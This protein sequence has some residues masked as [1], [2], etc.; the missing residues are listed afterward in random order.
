VRCRLEQLRL[1]ARHTVLLPAPLPVEEKGVAED[2]EDRLR[3]GRLAP[4]TVVD[5]VKSVVE[6]VERRPLQA[7]VG[8]SQEDVRI[9]V[10]EVLRCAS[11]RGDKKYDIAKSD[12]LTGAPAFRR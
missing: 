10:A 3:M 12:R 2:D 9:P 7:P 5:G 6:T 4:R 11:V 1:S 8:L